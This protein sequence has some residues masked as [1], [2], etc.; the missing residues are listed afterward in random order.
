MTFSVYGGRQPVAPSQLGAQAAALPSAP[1]QQLALSA[2]QGSGG[3][4]AAPY[5]HQ[6]QQQPMLDPALVD[7]PR[8][9]RDPQGWWH[10]PDR[11]IDIYD[12]PVHALSIAASGAAQPPRPFI[13]TQ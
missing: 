4:Q 6:H 1:G 7:V 2:Q 8:P 10:I 5:A 9:Y 13:R 12:P 3:Q 11:W